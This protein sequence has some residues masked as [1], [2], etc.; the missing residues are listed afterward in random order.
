[1]FVE[2]LSRISN[3]PLETLAQKHA[4]TSFSDPGNRGFSPLFQLFGDGHVKI[5]DTLS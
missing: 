1:L 4:K 3:L 5:P 2:T